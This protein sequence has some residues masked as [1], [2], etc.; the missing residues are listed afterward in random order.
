MP[1]G[2]QEYFS[3]EQSTKMQKEIVIKLPFRLS[4]DVRHIVKAKIAE[5][6]ETPL[7]I[8][9]KLV[10]DADSYVRAAVVNNPKIS[11][12]ILEK[13]AVDEI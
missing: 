6:P 12:G 4:F 11:L 8:L 3:N 2:F 7:A 10:V 5:R 9:E 1:L 13:L